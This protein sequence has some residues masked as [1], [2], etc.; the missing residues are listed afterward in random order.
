M[1]SVK[2]KTIFITGAASG[3]GLALTRHFIGEGARVVGADLRSSPELT[4]SGALFVSVDVSD[5][6]QVE[7]AFAAAHESVGL[8]DVLINNAGIALD[9]GPI[10]DADP[11]LLEKVF[12]VNVK[13]VYLGIKHGQ[14]HMNDGGSI[15]NTASAAALITMPE[16]TAYGL[17]K[18]SVLSMTR[19]AALQLGERN[20]RVNS[21]CPGTITTPMEPAD[22]TESKLTA[23]TTA[24]GRP[25]TTDE[26]LG[27][28]QYLASNASGYVSGTE[29]RVDGGWIAG[30]TYAA[31]ER[32]SS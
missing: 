11:T 19:N 17:S 7:R 8:L 16:Y 10:R 5:E 28:Y 18:A 13:G 12:A 1:F 21:V 22:S 14:R 2:G 31:M 3:I 23:R 29:I 32:L 24:L 20:I 30:L 27:A 4:D 15:I 9:E 6:H 25:G 26:L